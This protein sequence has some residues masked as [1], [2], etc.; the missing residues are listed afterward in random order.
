MTPDVLLIRKMMSRQNLTRAESAELLEAILRTDSEGWRLLAYSVA[1]Q[2]KG[3]TVEEILGMFDAMR[4]L[5]GEYELDLS[6]RRPMD[7]SS[8]GGSGVKKINVSTLS[9][10]IAGDPIVP[11]VKHSFWKVTSIT[12]SADALEAV[13]IHPQ[14]V[15]LP[16]IQTAI[17][18]V[19]VVFYSP[20]FVSGELRN[21]VNFGRVLGEHQVGVSTPFHMLAPIFTPIPLTYRMFGLNNP[22]QFEI[23]TEIFRGIGYRNAL[24]VRGFEGLDEASISSPSRVRGFRGEEEFDFVLLPEEV[25][26]N[27][28]AQ[29]EV[30]PVDAESNYRDFLRIAHGEETGPKRDLIALNAGLALWI[31]ERTPT[32]AEGVQMALERLA[33][34]MAAERLTALVEQHGSPDVL[35]RAR[36]KY[37]A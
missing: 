29:E 6:G 20:L 21:I 28:V 10:L 14:T 24:L 35:R 19:G 33:S 11:V 13:G 31:S 1:S 25:G 8:A 17:E 12:G 2:T 32:I 23:L 5:T 34:G 30:T 7:I 15:T 22:T 4:R 9:S 27:R 3:E 18:A 16:Q 36:E 26:L 37:L